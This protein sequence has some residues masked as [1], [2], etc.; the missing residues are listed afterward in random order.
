MEPTAHPI[1]QLDVLTGR[2]GVTGRMV[3]PGQ[4]GG[5]A[6]TEGIPEEFPWADHAGGGRAM[7][8]RSV[9]KQLALGVEGARIQKRSSVQ[10][11]AL[12]S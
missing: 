5:G 9:G 10:P 8:Q 2:C 12:G 11:W 4:R 6:K 3:A 7:C 1:G